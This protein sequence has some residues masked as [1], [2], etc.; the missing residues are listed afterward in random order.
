MCEKPL[1]NHGTVFHLQSLSALL[2]AIVTAA[3]AGSVLLR[4]RHQQSYR[5]FAAF[6]F[7]VFAWQVTSFFAIAVGSE[8]TYVLATLS[9]LFVPIASVRFFRPF[10]AD[11]RVRPPGARVTPRWMVGIASGFF[12]FILYAVLFRHGSPLRALPFKVLVF[13]FVFVGLYVSMGSVYQKYRRTLARVEKTRLAYLLV[14]G[15]V[16]ITLSAADFLPRIGV[17]F[18]AFGN[19]LGV[20]YLYFISQTL[21]RSRLLDLNELLGKMVVQTT[22]V[23]LLAA[24]FGLLVAWVPSEESGV[25]LF[26]TLVA[27]F[28]VLI[29]FEPLRQ[30]IEGAIQKWLF[31]EMYELRARIE[32]ARAVLANVIDIKEAVRVLIQRLDESRRVT[33]AAVYLLDAEGGYDL[34][35]HLGERPV[36]RIDAATRRTFFER[37]SST[38]SPVAIEQLE[39]EYASK[40]ALAQGEAETEAIDAIARTLDEM[41]AALCIPIL[42]ED[43]VLGLLALKDERLREAYAT[44]EVDLFRSVAAQMA[45][46]I[47]NSKVYERMKER[48]R[49]AALGE[50]AAGLAHEIR[51]PLGAI[52]GAAQLLLPASGE[53]GKP[54][55]DKG[56]KGDKGDKIDHGEREFLTIIVD[57]VN[58][59]NRVVSQFLD[60]AR[61]Y[62]GEPLLLDVNE[63]VRKSAQLISPPPLPGGGA[64]PPVEIVLSLGDE[65]PRVRAD[66][67]Q[68]RQVFLNLAINAVQAMAQVSTAAAPGKLTIT[69]TARRGGRRN[70]PPTGLEV[71]FRDTGPGI[72]QAEL[73]SLFIP[74]YT[75]KEKGTGLGLPIS[76]RIIEQHGG[77]IEV[78]SKL[79]GGS[80]FTVVLPAAAEEPGEKPMENLEKSAEKPIKA[81][82]P[83]KASKANKKRAS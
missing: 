21:F 31:R 68:L 33:H 48:D 20:I 76:Q 67:E 77:T 7:T 73:K 71:R 66:A 26:N 43:Q 14:G 44:D 74:F 38:R 29:L 51:N 58:R 12:T 42:A 25:F 27:S 60:Y 59:L 49:L 34:Q 78:R 15:V 30:V 41:N 47:Q 54:D 19:V 80:T 4:D 8:L 61:P 1:Y 24:I 10:L 22:L 64:P 75:T 2:A 46:T 17:P 11:P 39:R 3:I 40:S 65:L 50:M 56:D 57:E 18:P 45:I 35:G 63:V 62:R 5:R 13:L 79:N 81:E 28:V 36:D 72:P 82:T 23:L 37:L 52:K 16:A 32:A 55:K 70:S 9:A 69:T 6:S 83:E 53:D